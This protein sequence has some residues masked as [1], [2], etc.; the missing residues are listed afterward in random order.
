M[1]C[2]LYPSQIAAD[3]I[4]IDANSRLT[5][6][7][8]SSNTAGPATTISLVVAPSSFEMTASI[9]PRSSNSAGMVVVFVCVSKGA[10]ML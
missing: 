3:Q 6:D 5:A 4:Y 7:G 9:R 1:H 2:L 8:C 10:E